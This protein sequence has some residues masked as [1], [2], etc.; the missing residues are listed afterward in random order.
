MFI[1][2][3]ASANQRVGNRG[4]VVL[5]FPR[6]PPQSERRRSVAPFSLDSRMGEIDS[7][8]GKRESE[9]LKKFLSA[10]VDNVRKPYG[11]GVETLQR[12]CGIVGT[13][14]RDDF[15]KDPTGNRR[16]PRDQRQQRQPIGSKPTV[17]R[18]GVQPWRHSMP[19]PVALLKRGEHADQ[20][21]CPELLLGCRPMPSNPG[22]DHPDL[23]GWWLLGLGHQPNEWANEWGRQVGNRLRILG[24][25]RPKTKPRAFFAVDPKTQKPING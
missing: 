1:A 15:I 11:R 9:T 18:S 16:F 20:R 3:R 10:Q 14:N 17:M 4:S 7:V 5:R 2:R 19:T 6:R 25:T 23:T 12:T 13:T 24:W 8:V 22:A 21:R